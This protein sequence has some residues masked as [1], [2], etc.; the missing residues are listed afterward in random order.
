MVKQMDKERAKKIIVEIIRAAGGR[1]TNKT[2]LFKA[3][4]HAHLKYA[5][6]RP[7]VLSD[8]PIIRMPRGPA[9]DRFGE[10]LGELMAD[11]V[12]DLDSVEKGACEAFEFTLTGV[13]IPDAPALSNCALKA[14]HAGVEE[15][16]GKSAAQVS[17]ESHRQSWEEARDGKEMNIYL[18]VAPTPH[19]PILRDQSRMLADIFRDTCG[20]S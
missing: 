4:Y 3:F 14:I 20:P 10:L 16:R 19:D 18:D 9:I 2:N 5:E 6:L 13:E 17:E 12:V 1:F 8:W 11:G 15:V 7:D